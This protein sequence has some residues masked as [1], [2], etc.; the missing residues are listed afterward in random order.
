MKCG[1]RA[2]RGRFFLCPLIIFQDAQNFWGISI[3]NHRHPRRVRGRGPQ[4]NK[5]PRKIG[6]C[7]YLSG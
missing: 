5:T 6:T 4:H 1:L 2:Q 7:S 3:G